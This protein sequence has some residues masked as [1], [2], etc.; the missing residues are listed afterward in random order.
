MLLKHAFVS[1]TTGIKL[2]TR[3]DGRLFN[4]ASLRAKLNLKI[5][6]VRDLLFADDAALVAHSAQDLQTLLRQFSS[7]CSDFGLTI[8]LKK[9]KVVSKGTYFLPSIKIN[10]KE[11]ENVNNFLYLGSSFASNSSLDTEINSRIGKVSGTFAPVTARVWDNQKL[12]IRTKP[13]VYCSCVCSTLLYGSETWTSSI[14]YEKK[15]NT[16]YLRYLRRILRIAWQQK[17]TNEEVLRRISLTTILYL[18][19]AQ[20]SLG[21]SY[22]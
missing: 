3:T 4:L 18:Q 9:T 6:K 12:S 11:I 19:S 22:S 1:S 13:N 14:V 16:F 2:H 5:V 15:S 7:T 10:G 8:S 20:A 17:I 21:R